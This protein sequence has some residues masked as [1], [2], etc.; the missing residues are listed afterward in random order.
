MAKAKTVRFGELS[1]KHHPLSM[2]VVIMLFDPDALLKDSLQTFADFANKHQLCDHEIG[3][4]D[5]AAQGS[6]LAFRDFVAEWQ[7]LGDQGKS[8]EPTGSTEN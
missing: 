4:R 5:L 3:W 7:K 2:L 8:L 6:L 1:F